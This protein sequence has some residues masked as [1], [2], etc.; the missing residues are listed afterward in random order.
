VTGT[1]KSGIQ[2]GISP[3]DIILSGNSV[4]ISLFVNSAV[5]PTTFTYVVTFDA[6]GAST[7]VSYAINNQDDLVTT[8]TWTSNYAPNST[9]S[10]GDMTWTNIGFGAVL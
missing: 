9:S 7:L 10:F 1:D 8:G 5:Q 3:S 4:T 6:Q 2:Y